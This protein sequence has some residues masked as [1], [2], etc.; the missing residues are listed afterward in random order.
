[1]VWDDDVVA[2]GEEYLA[3]Y[4]ENS[5]NK[6][7]DP[8]RLWLRK[9]VN[10]RKELERVAKEV[11]AMRSATTHAPE[12]IAESAADYVKTRRSFENDQRLTVTPI[13][14]SLTNAEG[15][16]R[17]AFGN[18]ARRG[19]YVCHPLKPYVYF[20]YATFHR[21]L[22]L[23]KFYE[24]IT[25]LTGLRATNASIEKLRGRA[26]TSTLGLS[27]NPGVQSLTAS[28]GAQYQAISES[29][30]QMTLS[31]HDLTDPYRPPGLVW[32]AT[33]PFWEP[34]AVHRLQGFEDTY[35]VHITH[36]ESSSVSGNIKLP[37]SGVHLGATG[38]YEKFD[39]TIWSVQVSFDKSQIQAPSI[40][41]V[42]ERE[43]ATWFGD[44]ARQKAHKKLLDGVRN[45]W[46]SR[47]SP[48]DVPSESAVAALESP[49]SAVN[50]PVPEQPKDQNPVKPPSEQGAG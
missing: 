38:S 1:M 27:V 31:A 20:P 14:E 40:R 7:R 24:L 48:P 8:R 28:A 22:I 37:V 26:V 32:I 42:V 12:T 49:T 47:P 18:L 9:K 5:L 50:T 17:G 19:I 2:V 13:P 34:M 33:E 41:K 45:W 21:D 6:S 16:L 10:E 43:A 44:A 23:D 29:K 11:M 30:V 35:T 4:E 3:R 36:R 39:L 25:L 46:N 15:K